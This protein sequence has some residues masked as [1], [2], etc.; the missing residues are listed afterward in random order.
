[1]EG[2]I[3]SENVTYIIKC[4][5]KLMETTV[6]QPLNCLVVCKY[7]VKVLSFGMHDSFYEYPPFSSLSLF[8]QASLTSSRYIQAAM[9]SLVFA[10]MFYEALR[11]LII[12]CSIK[13]HY[14]E[15][16]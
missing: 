15:F 3:K 13:S 5:L 8:I 1:M 11:Y 4:R 2:R 16:L 7:I 12:L 14:Q 10:Q 6:L 9:I